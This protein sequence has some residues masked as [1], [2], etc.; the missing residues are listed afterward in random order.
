MVQL[1]AD[2]LGPLVRQQAAEGLR[3]LGAADRA[4]YFAVAATL[5]LSLH[6]PLHRLSNAADNSR[7]WL[8][9]AAGLAAAGD[10]SGRRAAVRRTLAIG[11]TSALV[12]LAVKSA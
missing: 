12:N 11:A 4:V 2:T 3:E 8:A 7:P 5:T 10:A 6:E 9:I 1:L